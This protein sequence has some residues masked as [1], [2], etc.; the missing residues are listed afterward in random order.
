[1]L[2][3]EPQAPTTGIVLL[4][5]KGAE[6]CAGALRFLPTRFQ[7]QGPVPLMTGTVPAGQK[8]AL[9]ALLAGKPLAEPP[10]APSL[11]ATAGG[12][13]DS[14]NTQA[15]RKDSD[16]KRS[17]TVAPESSFFTLLTF[18]R[19][20]KSQWKSIRASNAIE[21]LHEE[22]KRL[23]KTQTVLPSALCWLWARSRC[24]RWTAG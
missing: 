2:F 13:R 24:A 14:N 4:G 11:L 6:Q 20:P 16:L 3:D 22:F 19:F 10:T 1:V 17:L 12:A 18:S 9:G 7:L 5:S 15:K 23:I 8:L 21:R